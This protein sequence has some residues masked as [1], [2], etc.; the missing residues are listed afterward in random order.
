MINFQKKVMEMRKDWSGG[1]NTSRSFAIFFYQ[2]GDEGVLLNAKLC[3]ID[4]VMSSEM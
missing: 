1:E 2:W 4:F 3:G